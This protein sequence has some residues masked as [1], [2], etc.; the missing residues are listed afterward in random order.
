MSSVTPRNEGAQPRDL[1]VGDATKHTFELCLQFDAFQ[2][3]RS[4]LSLGGR[5]SLAATFGSDKE[6]VLPADSHGLH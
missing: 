2:F 1:L 5:R 6:V 4:D 3:G